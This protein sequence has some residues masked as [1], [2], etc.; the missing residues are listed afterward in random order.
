[1]CRT[2]LPC[3]RSPLL[4][5]G[6][7]GTG[8]KRWQAFVKGNVALTD[9]YAVMVFKKMVILL[10]TVVG[11]LGLEPCTGLIRTNREYPYCCSSML[12]NV[13]FSTCCLP[14]GTGC[15]TVVTSDAAT[16]NEDIA[17][18]FVHTGQMVFHS[19]IIII[20]ILYDGFYRHDCSRRRLM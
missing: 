5:A 1:M 2:G 3:R 18:A 20:T 9:I 6:G 11:L 13:P 12:T 17:W 14:G 8:A 15:D 16:L 19:F 10:V 7:G 4:Q